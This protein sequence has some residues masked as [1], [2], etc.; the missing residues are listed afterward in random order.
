MF[1]DIRSKPMLIILYSWISIQINQFG[2]SY[3][4]VLTERC[5][6]LRSCTHRMR[7]EFIPGMLR[8][9]LFLLAGFLSGCGTSEPYFL[10]TVSGTVTLDGQP[11]KGAMVTFSPADGR[12][13]SFGITNASGYFQ[14]RYNSRTKGAEVGEHQVRISPQG[15]EPKQPRPADGE[16]TRIPVQYSGKNFL[17]R[18]VK[19]GSNRINLNLSGGP[20]PEVIASK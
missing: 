4:R 14:L 8:C 7:S 18:E 6:T 11:L 15:V 1:T 2:L 12:R 17:S 9:L 20:D 19:P 13:E 16:S 3:A 5:S 10:G